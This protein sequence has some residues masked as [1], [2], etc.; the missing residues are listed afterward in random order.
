[1]KAHSRPPS[2][3][4][5]H[6]QTGIL[7]QALIQ[8]DLLDDRFVWP[9]SCVFFVERRQRRFIDDDPAPARID[10]RVGLLNLHRQRG[11]RRC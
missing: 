5:R 1:M 3:A 10:D 2:R 4:D 7:R 9:R 8:I 11:R 6:G